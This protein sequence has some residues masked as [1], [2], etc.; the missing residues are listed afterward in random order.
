MA[1]GLCGNC[2]AP[3]TAGLAACS[4]CQTPFQGVAQDGVNCPHCGDRNLPTNNGCVSCGTSLVVV[5]IFCS[6]PS[7][8]SRSTCVRCHE[9]F[10]GARERKQAREEAAKQQQ[11]MNL[12]SQG[13]SALGSAAAS[14]TGRGLLGQL[15]SEI[16]NEVKKG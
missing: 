9:A 8:L 16:V 13:L 14:P 3:F 6:S 11:V 1:Q 10:E 12:A 15:F 5:C 7:P 2:G 4:Y